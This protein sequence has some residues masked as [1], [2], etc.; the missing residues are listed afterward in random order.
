MGSTRRTNG[1]DVNIWPGHGV[2]ISG[3]PVCSISLSQRASGCFGA[4]TD[5]RYSRFRDMGNRFGQD[6]TDI[7][8]ADDGKI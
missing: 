7:S 6:F 1:H 8:G 5:D 2:F 3:D 4:I